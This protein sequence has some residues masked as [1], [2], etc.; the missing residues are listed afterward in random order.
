MPSYQDIET[1]LLVVEDKIDFLLRAMGQQTVESTGMVDPATNQPMV[2]VVKKTFLDI[3][4]EFQDAKLQ[5][6]AAKANWNRRS[7]SGVGEADNQTT[8]I[9]A[10]STN[11]TGTAAGSQI[12]LTD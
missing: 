2:R 8:G 3:Y 5:A 6:L 12:L 9:P 1:R 10:E 4:R 7:D 11:D